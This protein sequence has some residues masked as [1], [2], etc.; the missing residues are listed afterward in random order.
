M[1]CEHL[2]DKDTCPA[3]AEIAYQEHM[4]II[5]ASRDPETVESLKQQF[6][7]WLLSVDRCDAEF[8]DQFP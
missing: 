1:M 5:A 3:C 8:G 6:D 7:D 4:A 2:V